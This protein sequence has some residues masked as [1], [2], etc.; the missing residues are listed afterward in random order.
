MPRPRK[1]EAEHA[2]SGTTPQY[3]TGSVSNLT[4]SIPK[5]PS[6]L[7]TSAKQKFKHLVKQLAERRAVTAGDADLLT[8]YCST[9][10]RWQTT[11]EN[12]RTEGTICKYQRLAANGLP[13]IVEKPNLNLRIAEVAEKSMLSILTRLGLT[14]KDRES[15][16]PTQPPKPKYPPIDP[17]SA[18]GLQ[19]TLAKLRAEADSEK[20]QE[21]EPDLDL[22]NIDLGDAPCQ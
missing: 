1:T 10:E 5:P 11:L 20:Q 13:V 15:V 21:P 9:W 12:L 8:L 2:L 19:L 4:G 7:S 16:K 18:A 14:P 3:V 22:D 6:F 17:D